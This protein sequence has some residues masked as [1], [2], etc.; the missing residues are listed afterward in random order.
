MQNS[1]GCDLHC[2]LCEV[3][4]RCVHNDESSFGDKNETQFNKLKS[5][6]EEQGRTFFCGLLLQNR[7]VD[8]RFDPVDLRRAWVTRLRGLRKKS[9][10][11]AAKKKSR[12][13]HNANAVRRTRFSAR[14]VKALRR[15]QQQGKLTPEEVSRCDIIVQPEYLPEFKGDE[16]GLQRHALPWLSTEAELLQQKL[17]AEALRHAKAYFSN[18][19]EYGEGE[20]S[21]LPPPKDA[22]HWALTREARLSRAEERNEEALLEG[23]AQE[24]AE[25]AAADQEE[26][27][28]K[29]EPEKE[30][31]QEA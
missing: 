21:E 24:Q 9:K 10:L 23:A 11:S 1:R 27:P 3:G 19:R 22:P 31:N 13:V 26:A 17:E 6:A 29:D 4:Q 16:N 8:Q 14:M 25:A 30:E 20:P 2:P 5:Y 12:Q 7:I 15:L 28:Q 18:P